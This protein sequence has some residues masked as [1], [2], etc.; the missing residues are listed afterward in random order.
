[1]RLSNIY[2]NIFKESGSVSA[3]LCYR[4]S[5]KNECNNYKNEKNIG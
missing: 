3:Y 5:Y 4:R 1:M 2:W